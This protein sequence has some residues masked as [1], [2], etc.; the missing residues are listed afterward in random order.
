MSMGNIDKIFLR[1]GFGKDEVDVVFPPKT[2]PH[3][4]LENIQKYTQVHNGLKSISDRLMRG[5]Y[6]RRLPEEGTVVVRVVKSLK[7]VSPALFVQ[8]MDKSVRA[9]LYASTRVPRFWCD[10]AAPKLYFAGSDIEYGGYVIAYAKPTGR[11]LSRI[12]ARDSVLHA[13]VERAF[14]ACWMSGI[15]FTPGLSENDVIVDEITG[16]VQITRYDTSRELKTSVLE[17]VKKLLRKNEFDAAAVAIDGADNEPDASTLLLAKLRSTI[18][19]AM[20]RDSRQSVATAACMNA[21]IRNN[22][23]ILS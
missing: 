23:K 11:P 18:S 6:K 17:L 19:P 20:I 4:T 2:P 22:S 21:V 1:P 5:A 9:H 10:I 12:S 7:D 15:R 3:G 13:R 16:S 8:V 14:A